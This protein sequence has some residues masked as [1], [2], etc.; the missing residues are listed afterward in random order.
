MKDLMAGNAALRTQWAE[1]GFS[2][3]S[4]KL[5]EI[6]DPLS[7]AFYFL[8]F[9]AILSTDK[10][11]KE[12]A[13]YGQSIVHL[14]ERH[15]G[16]ACNAYDRLFKQQLAT[17]SPLPWNELSP[18][19]LA[20]TVFAGSTNRG[21]SCQLCNGVDHSQAACTLQAGLVGSG[22]S[23]DTPAKRAKSL[24]ACRRFNKGE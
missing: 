14:A 6:D 19:L 3:S 15:V 8:E 4:L 13:T 10:T 9:L 23:T 21:S 18:S 2:S 22:S 12:L 16:G 5:H 1:S 24:E 17:G 20:S 11:T 7:W